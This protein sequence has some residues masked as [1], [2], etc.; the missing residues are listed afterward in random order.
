MFAAAQTMRAFRAARIDE[1][2]SR[3]DEFLHACAADAVEA[4]G[5]SLIEPLASLGFGNVEFMKGTFATLAHAE[6]VAVVMLWA[7]LICAR[8]AGW[9][10]RDGEAL[11]LQHHC[12]CCYKFPRMV[13]ENASWEYR[14]AGYDAPLNRNRR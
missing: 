10:R 5:N 9:R 11:P 1:H 12:G 6:I 7:G 8:A 4:R 3:F 2:Q 14:V 13:T